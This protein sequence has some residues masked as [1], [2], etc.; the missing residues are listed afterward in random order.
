[1]L[2]DKIAAVEAQMKAKL[3]EARATFA[4]PGDKGTSVEDSF[5]A[6]LCQYLSRRLEVGNG[7]II[8]RK[9]RRSVQTDIVIVNEDHPFT[10]TPD[11]PGLFFIEGVC[12]AGEVKT[13]LTSAELKKA[14]ENSCQFKQLEMDPGKGT[15][16]FA[17]PSDLERFYKCPPWFL[18]AYESQLSLSRIQTGIEEFETENVVQSNRLL[19]AVFVLSE[20]WIINFGDGRGSLKFKTPE[21]MSLGGWHW[22]NSDSVLFY[23]L[24][25]LSTVMPRMIRFEPILPK[26]M[27]PGK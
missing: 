3:E 21:G 22:Q 20:G 1:M 9:G 7:E 13:N 17:N 12:A 23:L 14:L 24:G 16:A 26:Y 15:Q 4:H 5:R 11:L 6:F 10:F 25:W 19:D 27:L 8:D 2:K 18:V